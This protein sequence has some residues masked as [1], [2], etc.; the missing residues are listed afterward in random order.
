[1]AAWA[2]VAAT[3]AAQAPDAELEQASGFVKAAAAH[4]AVG[5]H[6]AAVQDYEKALAIHR[7][8]N[9]AFRE[10]VLLN[11]IGVA[12]TNAG[13]TEPALAALNQALTIRTERKD[14]LGV[15]YTLLAIANAHWYAGEPQAALDSYRKLIAQAAEV[16]N[17]S[18]LAHALN[19]GGLVLQSMGDFGEA[20]ERHNRALELFRTANEPLFIG[21]ALNNAGM[22]MAAMGR[23][24]EAR[25]NYDAALIIFRQL[26]DGR[27]QAY[28]FH[29]LGD[30]SL[31][32]RRPDEAVQYFRQ[33]L[34]RKRTARDRYG[35]AWTLARLAEASAQK[36]DHR[37]SALLLRQ[38][39][40]LHQ[41]VGD[42]IGQ[43]RAMASLG[44]AER[45]LGHID[46]AKSQL[47]EALNLI[48]NTRNTIATP[49]LRGS[50]F[51]SRQSVYDFLIDL[52][53]EAKDPA[54]LEIAERS[55]ARLLLDNLTGDPRTEALQ[56]DIYALGQRLQRATT[57]PEM[58]RVRQRL[59]TLLAAAEK[60]NSPERGRPATVLHLQSAAPEGVAI[61]EYWLGARRS[62]AFVIRTDGIRL[63]PLPP[64]KEIEDRVGALLEGVTARGLPVANEAPAARKVRLASA[65]AN[66]R[67]AAS[68]LSKW[69]WPQFAMNGI[70][71][72]VVVPHE[73][74][75]R[76]PFALLDGF[77]SLPVSVLP[78]A[79]IA[80]FLRRSTAKGDS[81]AIYAAPSLGNEWPP[82]PFAKLEAE[83]ITRLLPPASAVVKVGADAAGG[84]AIG[85]ELS[86]HRYL[87]FAT[88]IE[89]NERRPEA[90]G[91][92]LKGAPLRLNEIYGLSLNADLV[93]LSACR[94]ALGKEMR[95]EGLMGLAYGFLYAGANRVL[96]TLWAVDDQATAAFMEHFYAALLSKGRPPAAALADARGA[97]RKQP[98]WEH[99]WYWAAFTLY[100]NAQ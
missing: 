1:M 83:R 90:S 74:L 33:S 12:W 50:Y 61:V 59:Q 22:A 2:L 40:H 47:Y 71:S 82:L 38:A 11:N 53:V 16:K 35:E 52:L 55:R 57:L 100:G 58:E 23:S 93:T 79:S 39:I 63:V 62:A 5:R 45:E 84:P 42:R 32:A 97:M 3:V 69:L 78:S 96:A 25:K 56:R 73:T 67:A 36:G 54:A 19:N 9:D 41:A 49:E 86:R 72:V 87:H 30:L 43:S 70:R 31:Q 44:R 66:W 68:D 8:R 65:D 75:A 34:E 37:G 88:H 64:A 85:R 17:T 81:M 95:G 21:Y 29:N 24:E 77:S 51:A 15:A 7:R 6:E 98:R 89:I 99:P 26:E 94:S 46:I 14:A 27:A 13:E 4:A 76:A 60:I 80:P 18:L 92:V 20:L 48:E 28:A 91:I 10:G